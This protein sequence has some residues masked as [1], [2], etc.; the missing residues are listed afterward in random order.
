[1]TRIDHVRYRFDCGSTAWHVWAVVLEERLN[2]PFR[3]ELRL[4]AT[5]PRGVA[6]LL[7]APAVLTFA[8][9]DDIRVF[10]GEVTRAEVSCIGAGAM[11]TVRFEPRLARLAGS[12]RSRIFQE[13][14]TLDVVREVLGNTV[15]ELP[16]PPELAA[17]RPRLDYCVQYQESDLAFASRLLEQEGI[18]WFLDDSGDSQV[19]RLVDENAAFPRQ[20]EL[21][22]LHFVT[23]GYDEA[24]EATVQ[25]LAF[26][27]RPGSVG[28]L[29]RDW[30]WMANPAIATETRYPE[31]AAGPR[32]ERHHPRRS[33]AATAE[34]GARHEYERRLA[35]A[36][37]G[38]GRSNVTALASGRPA[39]IVLGTG[40]VVDV[41]VTAVV[42]RGNA[43]GVVP[44]AAQA[45][46]S[47]NY[48]NT[49]E[50]Q[51]HDVAYRP[52]CTTPRP[53]IHG[54]Q[55]AVVV[56]PPDEEIHTDE[57]GRIRVRMHWDRATNPDDEASCWLRVAQSWAGQ[58]WG[59]MFIPRVGMEVLVAF[60]DGDPDRPMCVG[61]VYNGAHRPPYA[62]PKDRTKST[63]RTQSSPGGEGYNELTFEDAAGSERVFLRAQRDLAAQVLHDLDTRVD[64]GETRRVGR[65]RYTEIGTDDML[66]VRKDEIRHVD[67]AQEVR[68]GGSVALQIDG[69]PAL[70]DAAVE[71][72]GMNV[73]IVQGGY[74]LTA[75]QRIELVCGPSSILLT[76]TGVTITGPAAVNVVC[77]AAMVALAPGALSLAAPVL[78]ISAPG[79][80]LGLG[81]TATLA[82]PGG[83]KLECGD[84]CELTLN[85]RATITA[86]EVVID[87]GS[88]FV[89]MAGRVELDGSEEAVVRSDGVVRL[90]DPGGSVV[91]AGGT[92]AM[93][94]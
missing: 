32:H 10:R 89:A 54:L 1:V 39:T 51:P 57:H 64:G 21:A 49:F 77:G 47:T 45:S 34:T 70:G 72:P 17:P 52:P 76:P 90:A 86:G 38:T 67:G 60:L 55:T 56:G 71:G 3:A 69:G 36:V 91:L 4:V 14:T 19:L 6:D 82:S 43:P 53:R 68:I 23:D 74:R 2:R 75:P 42:H 29:E 46:S 12:V 94:D 50:C 27:H 59:T 13:M 7:Q 79:A 33:A 93:S 66:R 28:V 30:T 11:A 63:I 84:E 61:C 48:T 78:S 24:T 41:L 88:R 18:A 65:D 15:D 8:R 58:G 73:S 80:T 85:G 37:V 40:E 5:E 16:L 9:G 81:S 26:T 87:A 44:G 83:V 92:I 62:L 20:H 31:S 25:S 35:S 22:E